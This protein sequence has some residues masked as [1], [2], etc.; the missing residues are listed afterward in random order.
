MAIVPPMVPTMSVAV[1]MILVVFL[2]APFSEALCGED[3]ALASLQLPELFERR[4]ELL[5]EELRLFPRGEVAVWP[6][7][8]MA[9][10][11]S[12][13]PAELASSGRAMNE[14]RTMTRRVP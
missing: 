7:W 14:A 3:R 13:P 4:T 8:V 9:V 1:A 2:G 10:L 6:Y 11:G 5:R 12:R